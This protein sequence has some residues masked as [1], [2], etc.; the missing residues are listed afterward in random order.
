VTLVSYLD[1]PLAAPEVA[2]RS[3]RRGNMQSEPRSGP[4]YIVRIIQ[5]GA[6]AFSWEICRKADGIEVQRS[7]SRFATRIEAIVDSARAAATLEIAVVELSSVES[8]NRT[9]DQ[10]NPVRPRSPSLVVDTQ[11]PSEQRLA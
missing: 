5:H 10:I 4:G 9:G 6:K 3:L 8:E 11:V 7:T 2:A 1:D